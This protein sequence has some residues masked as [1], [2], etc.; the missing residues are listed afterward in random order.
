M[1]WFNFFETKKENMH[2][3]GRGIN[4]NI[5]P[6]EED[7][8]NYSYEAFEKK[9][10]IDAYEYFFKSIEN[11]TDETSSQN[12]ILEKSDE[13]LNF[14]IY[15]GT[16]KIN[17]YVTQEHLYAETIVTK[18]DDAH[19]ALKRFI[20]EKNYQLTYACYFID[21][22]YI[23]LKLYLD[24]ITITPQKV[25]FPLREIALNADFDKEY[26]VSEFPNTVLEDI[27]HLEQPAEEELQ[28]K[29]RYLQEWI[30]TLWEKNTA[31]ASSDNA[32][33]Y[34]FSYLTFLMK[35]DY[36]LVPN[37]EIY[38]KLSKKVQEYFSDESSNTEYKNE[39]LKNYIL[40]LKDISFEE[41]SKNFYH[42]KYTFN[43]TDKTSQEEI[44]LFISESLK[45]IRWYKNNRYNL[46][47]PTIYKY[48]SFYIL[49]NYGTHP[50]LR[51]LLHM[52]VQI[53]NQEFFKELG[54]QTLYY[55]DNGSFAKKVI[56]SRIDNIITPYQQRFKLL[57][58]FG[59]QLNYTSLNEFSNSF[60]LQLQELDFQEI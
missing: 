22:E 23:K 8:F 6:Q 19:V 26:M 24:N 44:N 30:K 28:I 55:E 52:L 45:K 31:Y 25:F 10:V 16:A 60:Y 2:I 1:N 33:M 46:I 48:I 53:Q 36:L 37:Y 17:G 18:K 32:G 15:Q 20:L 21:E 27:S 51:A 34:A 9:E 38:Q 12:I 56:V 13:K 49:Y 11:F 7:Y 59:E 29:Y 40:K 42:A 4:A 35:V 3:F 5:S 57:R 58:A 41:F 43:P 14:T 39:E 54:Y 50:V 47:I